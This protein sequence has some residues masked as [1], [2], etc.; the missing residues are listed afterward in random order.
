LAITKKLDSIYLGVMQQMLYNLF[1]SQ[2][3]HYPFTHWHTHNIFPI[4]F[5]REIKK[6][7]PNKK[8]YLDLSRKDTT[9]YSKKKTNETN[10]YLFQIGGNN[11]KLLKKNKVLFWE[12]FLKAFSNDFF[13]ISILNF[14]LPF[15]SH[16]ERQK[17]QK[18]SISLEWN[19]IK[20]NS[21][22]TLLPHTDVSPK[23]LNI[24]FYIPSSKEYSQ[25]GTSIYLP[26][27]EKNRKDPSSR[28]QYLTDSFLPF[29]LFHKLKTFPYVPNSSF[30]FIRSDNSFHAVEPL[31]QDFIER[32]ILNFIITSTHK[33][34]RI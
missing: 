20:N 8:T 17:I 4:D 22:F 21:D 18:E 25:C 32:D 10:N 29:N 7:L 2:I 1:N 23:L 5:F 19:L 13:L 26:K 31:K 15:F 28:K 11:L 16:K 27:I 24:L 30:S 33:E 3:K 12:E 6:N 9:F 14:I 34:P